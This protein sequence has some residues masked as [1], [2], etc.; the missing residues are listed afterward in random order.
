[1]THP[2]PAPWPST[3]RGPRAPPTGRTWSRSPTAR[4]GPGQRDRPADHRGGR[5]AAGTARHHGVR[6]ALRPAAHRRGRRARRTRRRRA[7]AAVD[8]LP[9]PRGPARDVRGRRRRAGPPARAG[10]A[11]GPGPGGPA[12]RGRSRSRRPASCWSPPGRATPPP[13]RTSAPRSGPAR[14]A[15]GRRGARRPRC[16]VS[17]DRPEEVLRPGDAVSPYLLS[18]GLFSRDVEAAAREAGASLRRRAGDHPLVVD[19]VVERTLQLADAGSDRRTSVTT[20]GRP[21]YV[22]NDLAGPD[23]LGTG[24]G[25]VTTSGRPRTSERPEAVDASRNAGQAGRVLRPVSPRN[26]REDTVPPW[27]PPR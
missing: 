11:A 21:S 14:R 20:S 23:P 12:A 13:A 1:M 6:R 22:G 3:T 10:P 4:V 24:P 5:S 18:P 27:P 15:L 16:P 26:R 25:S 17:G 19:L 8:R 7:A 9:R 2:V